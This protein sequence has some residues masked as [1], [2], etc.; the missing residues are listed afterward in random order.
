M[1]EC[2]KHRLFNYTDAQR[3]RLGVNHRQTPVNRP[4]CPVHSNQHDGQG[5]VDGN[6]GSLPHYEPNSFSQCNN[7]TL[8]KQHF[9]STLR[10]STLG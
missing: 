2:Y 5:R 8:L 7:Q 3:N 6:Y 1:T 4:R 9:V 10:C